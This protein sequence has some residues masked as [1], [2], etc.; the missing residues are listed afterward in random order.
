MK[1]FIDFDDVIFNTGEFKRDFRKMFFE[2]GIPV[3]VF[4]RCYVNP[5]DTR[6]IKTF[7]PWMQAERICLELEELDKV[8]ITESV[9]KFI[10]D[11][12]SYT[13]SDV[14]EFVEAIGRDDI[15]I[16][17]FGEK[18]FQT[19]KIK[20]SHVE[21][22]IPEIYITEASKAQMLKEI[23]AAKEIGSDEKIFFIDDRSEQIEDIKK[24]L[25][26]ITTIFLKRPEGRY[27]EQAKTEF[28]DHVAHN[29]NEAK[30]LILKNS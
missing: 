17:S 21:K 3:E 29:L 5:Q 6:A 2:Q 30:A 18:I 4:D 1:V 27:Q 26:Q 7:D 19:E 8:K 11:I 22:I 14:A 15:A 28:C 23:L 13:F 12:S 9:K 16:V 25:P 20:N 24:N 10:Q